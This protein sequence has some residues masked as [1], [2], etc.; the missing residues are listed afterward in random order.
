MIQH[1]LLRVHPSASNVVSWIDALDL[2]V[3]REYAHEAGGDG[4]TWADNIMADRGCPDE[5]GLLYVYGLRG[6][7]EYQVTIEGDPAGLC[8]CTR[9]QH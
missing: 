3:L 9:H 7:W 2:P 6:D 8:R 1:W 5:A 4:V